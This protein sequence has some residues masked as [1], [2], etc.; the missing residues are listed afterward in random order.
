MV[1]ELLQPLDLFCGT[2]YQSNCAIQCAIQ[3]LPTDC[4][5]NSRRETFWEPWTRRSVTSDM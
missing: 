5:D 3:T 2:P 1:T 4:F